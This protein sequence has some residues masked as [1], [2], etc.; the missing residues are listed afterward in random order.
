ME[1]HLEKQTDFETFLAQAPQLN[2]ACAL[3]KGVVY[4]VR[5]EG[6]EE[7]TIREIR[8]LDKLI[9]ELASGDMQHR[10]RGLRPG[11]AAARQCRKTARRSSLDAIRRWDAAA[12]AVTQ[13]LRPQ[14]A[15]EGMRI[16]QVQG[17]PPGMAFQPAPMGATTF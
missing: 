11:W 10:M 15:Y 16:D 13:V 3:I 12:G 5:V 8:S 2:P 17:L 9:D 6:I 14:R 1:A 7:P 4:G